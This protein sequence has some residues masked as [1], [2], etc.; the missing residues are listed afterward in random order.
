MEFALAFS[1]FTAGKTTEKLKS[2]LN[3][4]VSNTCSHVP[5]AVYISIIAI[6]CSFFN[7]QSWGYTIALGQFCNSLESWNLSN[8]TPFTLSS[9]VS[10]PSTNSD[11]GP[12]TSKGI[13]ATFGPEK[14]FHHSST[15]QS[16][17]PFP[18]FPIDPKTPLDTMSWAWMLYSQFGEF[19]VSSYP[20]PHS[21]VSR[22]Y[23]VSAHEVLF[24]HKPFLYAPAHPDTNAFLRHSG[25]K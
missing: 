13:A 21:L 20:S 12:F 18:T 3:P 10:V 23:N 2:I 16:R 11:N 5:S 24:C 22:F 15:L 14:A 8:S 25:W 19:Q 7:F 9:P 4:T 6:Q 1:Y 17:N